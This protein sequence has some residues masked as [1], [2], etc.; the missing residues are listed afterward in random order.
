MKKRQPYKYD[1][2]TE[3]DE[4]DAT[5]MSERAEKFITGVSNRIIGQRDAVRA[6]GGYYQLFVG[7][8]NPQNR[9]IGSLLFL[10]PTGVGK[11]R[12]I[13]AAAEQLF[14]NVG[15]VVKVDCAEFQHSHEIAKLIGSP[16]G[17]LGH[18]ETSPRLTQENLDKCHTETDKLT[19]V[20]FDE[21]EKASD[22]L[23]Q[24]LLGILDKATLTLGDNR[25]V[26]FSR[27]IVAMTSNLGAREMEKSTE[28]GIGFV[29]RG[30]TEEVSN[31]K[32]EK[33]AVEAA[34]K[35]FSPEFMNRIDKVIVFNSLNDE[36]LRDVLELELDKVQETVMRT[37][38]S[39][40]VLCHTQAAKDFLLEQGT[41]RRYNARHLR[42]AVENHV[43]LGLSNLTATGQVQ[44]GDKVVV[45]IN[46]TGD[47]LRFRKT[48]VKPLSPPAAAQNGP[49]TTPHRTAL[50][51]CPEKQDG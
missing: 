5:R 15:A 22:S 40:F 2:T 24:L 30:D 27:C 3:F 41:D 17:Y 12:L 23:W 16:P 19:L 34:R 46:D 47:G 21:I 29:W 37:G 32:T 1:A 51:L 39:K 8:L 43:T 28:G 4:L 50:A 13:E 48:R 26:N 49:P 7:Q 36:E 6:L 25:S 35:R 44:N 9:P 45:D 33:T 42:R 38:E 20:L 18:R 14:D 10:G 31:R 11:T